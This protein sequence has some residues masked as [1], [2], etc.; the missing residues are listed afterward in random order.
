MT[1]NEKILRTQAWDFFAIVAAQRLTVIKFYVTLATLLAGGLLALIHKP[2]FSATRATLGI[3]L[4]ILSFVFWKW[5]RRSSDLIKL[6]EGLLK[7]YEKRLV[8]EMALEEQSAGMLF[9]QEEQ[10]T[11]GKRANGLLWKG[12]FTYRI[13][14]NLLYG[15]FAL[16]GLVI[17][18]ASILE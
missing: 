8:A 17:C 10:I 18:I 4:A 3:L 14:L 13:C 11:N 5:D 12:Y 9:T 1:E 2:V 15:L 7:H 6:A 16:I